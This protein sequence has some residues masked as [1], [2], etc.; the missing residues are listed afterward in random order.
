MQNLRQMMNGIKNKIDAEQAQ[1]E[2]K[3]D[4][5]PKPPTFFEKHLAGLRSSP[6]LDRSYIDSVR[7]LLDPTINIAIR[8][9]RR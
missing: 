5:K 3:K 7:P 6:A 9:R 8:S 4:D 2:K 1:Q